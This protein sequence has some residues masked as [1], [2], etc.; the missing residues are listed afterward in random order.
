MPSYEGLLLRV[1]G[2][3]PEKKS[4]KGSDKGSP[5][6]LLFTDQVSAFIGLFSSL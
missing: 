1:P 6:D 4:P 5:E 3:S 2:D